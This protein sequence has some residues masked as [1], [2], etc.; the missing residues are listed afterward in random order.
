ME[1]K[2]LVKKKKK[3]KKITSLVNKKKNSALYTMSHT[4][5][6]FPF[7]FLQRMMVSEVTDK[8]V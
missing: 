3:F 5:G 6:A 1:K 4:R 8:L 2:K 7:F